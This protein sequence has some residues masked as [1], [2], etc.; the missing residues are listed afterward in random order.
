MHLVR[1]YQLTTY[2]KLDNLKMDHQRARKDQIDR[3]LP[4]ENL[5]FRLYMIIMGDDGDK[6][7]SQQTTSKSCQCSQSSQ[8]KLV[9][10]VPL[11]KEANTKL[12]E[13]H[14]QEARTEVGGVVRWVLIY[15]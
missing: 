2:G 6:N 15:H 10:T 8:V 11:R 9:N 3:T 13:K 1:E 7:Y 12:M 14:L 4:R 5:L